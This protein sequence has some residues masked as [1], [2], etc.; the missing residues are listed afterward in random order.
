[1]NLVALILPLVA[2]PAQVVT[3]Q[4]RAFEVATD[5]SFGATKLV[6]TSEKAGNATVFFDPSSPTEAQL[7][8]KAK[9]GEIKALGAP[10]IRTLSGEIAQIE[11]AQEEGEGAG[12][13]T[14]VQTM[15]VR[16]TVNKDG[17][18]TLDL[19]ALTR[20]KSGEESRE[21]LNSSASF[22]TREGK[23]VYFLAPTKQDRKR[24]LL[25]SVRVSASS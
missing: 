1:M 7:L 22:T 11:T 13:T 16:P 20:I 14:T 25:I 5:I 9:K 19:S 12:R 8:E 10:V 4:L 6:R 24:S 15:S 3:V 23:T 21:T 18:I 17:S 2:S